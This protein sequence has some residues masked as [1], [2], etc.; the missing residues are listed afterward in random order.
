VQ[1]ALYFKMNVDTRL[2]TSTTSNQPSHWQILEPFT[3]S[4]HVE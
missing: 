3:F 2:K 1:I 4:S